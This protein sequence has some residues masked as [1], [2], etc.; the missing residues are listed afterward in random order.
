MK[1]SLALISTA[2]MGVASAVSPVA[3]E[4][5]ASIKADSKMGM[6]L[7]SKARKL[8]ED[9]EVDMTWVTGYSIK[10]QGCHHVSQ[11]NEEADGEEDVRVATKRLV[12]FRLCPTD[13][14]SSE[15]AAGCASGY[16]DYII[17]MNVFLE[18]YIQNKQEQEEYMCEYTMNNVCDCEDGDD[19]GDDFNA[20][21][22]EYDCYMDR[23]MDYCVENNP[24]VDDEQE[25][26]QFELEDYMECGQWEA[27]DDDNRRL[28]EDEEV[29]YY[30]GPYCADQGGKIYLGM[31][32][33]E[34]CTNFVD[35]NGGKNT[36]ADLA[37][38]SLPYS[39]ESLIGSDCFSCMQNKDVEEGDDNNDEEAEDEI[40]EICEQVYQQSG[41]CETRLSSS[42]G[43]DINEG[44]CNYIEGIKIVRR[45]G[46]VISG[47]SKNK[48]A[49]AFIG[50]FAVS[51]VLLGAYV[52]YLKTK[53]DRAKIN[54]SD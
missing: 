9:G 31:F 51:F 4:K 25:Q 52:Y 16:G 33:D 49:S 37:G 29:G 20:D 18:A 45:N 3:M 15:S 41:K 11:W 5:G 21:Y 32:N 44:G 28:E 39:R 17:D 42:T 2:F 34:E 24:Y 22:C 30:L 26:E 6:N 8:E 40:K 48:V 50:I 19:K 7:L 35:E 47:G 27:P 53:L 14:C 23:G 54:L 1:F 10:F 46:T 12:R 13:V 43:A 38:E 36:Y